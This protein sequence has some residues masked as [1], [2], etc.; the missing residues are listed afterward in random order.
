MPY[1]LNQLCAKYLML[2]KKGSKKKECQWLLAVHIVIP[3]C[4]ILGKK[5]IVARSRPFFP[6]CEYYQEQISF[7]NNHQLLEF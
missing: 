4:S 6:I 1:K 5:V 2:I 3:P 7:P